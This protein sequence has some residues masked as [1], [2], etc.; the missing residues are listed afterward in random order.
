MFQLKNTSIVFAYLSF[1]RLFRNVSITQLYIG[2]Q[3]SI[4]FISSNRNHMCKIMVVLVFMIMRCG[5]S[6]HDYY[7]YAPHS[8]ETLF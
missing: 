6:E 8:S 3:T 1:P 2:N 7:V 4:V 5:K